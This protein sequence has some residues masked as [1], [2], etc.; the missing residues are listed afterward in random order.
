MTIEKRKKDPNDDEK[1]KVC[2]RGFV[3]K[4]K[5]DLDPTLNAYIWGVIRVKKLNMLGDPKHY[6]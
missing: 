2:F 4:I 6:P 5:G 1:V 3:S